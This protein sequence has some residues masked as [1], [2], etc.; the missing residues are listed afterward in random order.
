VKKKK[1]NSK[2]SP[3][4]FHYINVSFFWFQFL[5][6]MEEPRTEPG[7][8]KME[9]SIDPFS[10]VSQSEANAPRERRHRRAATGVGMQE[11]SS[12]LDLESEEEGYLG[13]VDK[14]EAVDAE[15]D[16][17]EK[18]E[19]EELGEGEEDLAADMEDDAP[20]TTSEEEDEDPGNPPPRRT[21][22]RSEREEQEKD[23]SEFFQLLCS[24]CGIKCNTFIS[25]SSHCKA[26]HDC[27]PTVKCHCGKAF[28]RRS[29]LIR[30]RHQHLGVHRFK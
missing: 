25:L 22:A 6:M 16:S 18:E 24:E 29:H 13:C 11:L 20:S 4:S 10:L 12:D 28:N 26:S 3:V 27:R 23:L 17:L 15:G 21:R 8:I 2:I 14:V 30:H 7:E 5:S 19:D 9:V 1:K